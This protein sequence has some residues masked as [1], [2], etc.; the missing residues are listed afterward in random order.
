MGERVNRAWGRQACS[1]V[2]QGDGMQNRGRI[3][4]KNLGHFKH[5]STSCQAWADFMGM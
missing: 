3:C 1:R 4:D 2:E 5:C